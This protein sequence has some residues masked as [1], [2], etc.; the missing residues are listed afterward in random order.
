[1]AGSKSQIVEGV[2][3]YIHQDQGILLRGGPA[4]KRQQSQCP[5]LMC[6]SAPQHA[7]G[8]KSEQWSMGENGGSGLED[9]LGSLTEN[10]MSASNSP[11][12]TLM[13]LNMTW[14]FGGGQRMEQVQSICMTIK[15]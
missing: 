12:S 10:T 14:E 9:R 6:D 1:M 8:N 4:R 13:H 11:E 3:K 2:R 7:L 5:A 15:Q